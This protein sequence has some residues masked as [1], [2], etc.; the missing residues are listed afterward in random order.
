MAGVKVSLSQLKKTTEVTAFEIDNAVVFNF[1]DSLPATERDDKLLRA[2][3]IG[4]LAMQED[5]IGSFLSSVN[6]QLGTELESLKMIFDLKQQLFYKSTGKGVLAESA[7]SECLEQYVSDK[8]LRDQVYLTGNSA[9]KLPRN[10]TG[11]IICTVDG[12]NDIRIAIECKFDKSISL[13]E[14]QTKNIFTKKSD[15]ATSQLIEADA[16][17]DS[18][19]AI[20]VFDNSCV[21]NSIL[22]KTDS[23]AY[24]AGVG[25]ICIVDT[26]KG[27]YTNLLIAYSMARDISLSTCVVEFDADV[28]CLI[29][30]RMIKDLQD[31]L[32][33]KNL[34]LA[35][36]ENS[37]AILKQLEKSILCMEFNQTYLKKFLSDGRL[38][39]SDLLS[40]YQ[41]EEI[42]DKFKL[43]ETEINAL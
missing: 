16:N 2:I 31:V 36:I 33:I 40:F 27:D 24:I 30:S 11:D 1:F 9:G 32:T 6:N 43:I 3:Y 4:V 12:N 42:K 19:A 20:I 18:K 8:G 22:R 7:I 34:V 41:G 29:I 13:G 23:V 37:K 28:L 38:T 25:F 10:K 35:N 26:Q 5:R 15:T 14:I 39:K 17:R 21:D